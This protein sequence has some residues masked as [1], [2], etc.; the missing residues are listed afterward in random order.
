MIE[1]DE[2]MTAADATTS[3]SPSTTA[4]IPS[5]LPIIAAFLA[6][7]LA[8]FLKLFTSWYKERRWDSKRMLDSGGM[9]SSH[10]ATVTALAVAIGLQD[11][12]GGPAFA[13][14]LVMYDASGVRLH[15]GRQ[16]ELLNQIVYELPPEHPLS[17]VRP[18]RDSLGHTPLQVVAGAVLGCVVAYLMRNTK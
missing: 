18:L 15:A 7:A 3:S 11:G 5:N 12:V 13:I 8:Q 10:S 4:T 2:V 14:A 6:C 9:P 17:S 1:T 16:A